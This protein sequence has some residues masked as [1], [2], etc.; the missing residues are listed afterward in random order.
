LDRPVPSLLRKLVSSLAVIGA[1][2]VLPVFASVGA[3]TDAADPF[4]SSV[5]GPAAH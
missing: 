1:A 2:A 4:P 3:F 5:E